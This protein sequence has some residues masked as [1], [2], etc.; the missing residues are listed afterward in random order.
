MTRVVVPN[1]PQ[2]P[3]YDQVASTTLVNALIAAATGKAPAY[4]EHSW[5]WNHVGTATGESTPTT[6]RFSTCTANLPAEGM[7]ATSERLRASDEIALS[8]GVLFGGSEKRTEMVRATAFGNAPRQAR[9][10]KTSTI[11]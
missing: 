9:I 10:M 3:P 2:L 7:D 8:S 1:N 4:E 5:V 11:I 6:S